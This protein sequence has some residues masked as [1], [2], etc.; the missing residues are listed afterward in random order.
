[1]RRNITITLLGS[2]GGLAKGVLSLLNKSIDDINSPIYKFL[3]NSKIFLI[4]INQKEMSYYEREFKNLSGQ[5]SLY[6][7]YLS[8]YMKDFTIGENTFS[9]GLLEDR[10]I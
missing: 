5:L 7:E 6:G 9:E 1:M 4:D 10:I 3:T 8:Y 2:S